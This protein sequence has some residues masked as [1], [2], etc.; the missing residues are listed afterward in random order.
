[1]NLNLAKT[2]KNFSVLYIED[3]DGLRESVFEML[4][5]FFKKVYLAQDGQKAFEILAK[6]TPDLII[7]D[8]KMPKIDGIS[9]IKE[10]RKQGNKTPIIIISAYT[11]TEDLLEAVELSIVSYVTKPITE[12]KLSIALEKFLSKVTNVDNYEICDGWSVDFLKSVIIS[13]AKIYEL[14]S[15]ENKFLQILILNKGI[16]TYSQM[17]NELWE[18]S[19]VSDNAIRLF[20]KDLR[21]KCPKNFLKNIQNI[22]Y[23]IQ[24]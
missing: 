20:I 7:T 21:K 19:F 4:N 12:T 2:L 14:T 13:P 1:M 6:S 11:E 17:E 9:F 15:K 23:K 8:I 18:K 3:E 16:I 10:I 5:L 24:I 22:G